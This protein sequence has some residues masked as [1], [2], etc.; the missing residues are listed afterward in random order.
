MPIEFLKRLKPPH[1]RPDRA[2]GIGAAVVGEVVVL[3]LNV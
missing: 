3:V 2:D 1:E